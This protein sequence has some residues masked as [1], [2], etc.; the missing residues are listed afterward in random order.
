MADYKD[1]YYADSSVDMS[2]AAISYAEALSVGNKLEEIK[3]DSAISVASQAAR[4]S[5]F[6][7]PV[8]GDAV[9]RTDTGIEQRYYTAYNSKTNPGGKTPSSGTGGWFATTSN[10]R[11]IISSSYLKLPSTSSVAINQIGEISFTNI[12]SMTINNCFFYN[13]ISTFSS[14]KI[15]IN[16]TSTS[17]TLSYPTWG[18]TKSG[19]FLS[20]ITHSATYE[21]VSASVNTGATYSSSTVIPATMPVSINKLS[22]ELNLEKEMPLFVSGTNLNI[23]YHSQSFAFTSA[24]NNSLQILSGGFQTTTTNRPDGFWLG[25]AGGSMTMTGTMKVYGIG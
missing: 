11:P 6:P 14:Y 15:L 9:W 18:L 2:A 24:S 3:F 7:T 13:T 21:G 20:S 8:Q 23:S 5:L 10:I 4:N 17:G 25:S 12:T 22:F 16:I 1:I 19:S